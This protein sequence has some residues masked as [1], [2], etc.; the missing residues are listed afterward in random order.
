MQIAAAIEDQFSP[1]AGRLRGKKAVVSGELVVTTLSGLSPQ[2]TPLLI[3]FQR[4]HPEVRI[5][6]VAEDVA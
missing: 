1:M 6:L 5:S 3:E 4:V 2:F